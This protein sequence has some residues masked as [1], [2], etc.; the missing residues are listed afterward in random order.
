MA[1]NNNIFQFQKY[2]STQ[3]H[4]H[5]PPPHHDTT[6][7]TTHFP[8]KKRKNTVHNHDDAAP[9]IFQCHFCP[10]N[11]SSYKALGGHQNAHK[12]ERAAARASSVAVVHSSSPPS[13]APASQFGYVHGYPEYGGYFGNFIAP[14]VTAVSDV[15]YGGEGGGGLSLCPSHQPVMNDED[16]DDHPPHLNLELT[17]GTF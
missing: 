17:I 7:T 5:H 13:Y 14:T 11:F 12:R 15:A 3:Q 1:E 2:P 10:R 16:E 9:K 8:S 4:H 6:T